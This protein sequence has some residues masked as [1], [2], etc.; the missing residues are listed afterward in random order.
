M[1]GRFTQAYS[2]H[3]LHELYALVG[4]ASNLKPH[5]NIAPTATI[6]VVV[7]GRD[8]RVLVPMRWGLIPAWWSKSEKEVPA[9]FNARAE[10]VA[11]K[12]MFKAAFER[13]R[14]IVPASGYYDKTT[15]AGRQPYYLSAEDGGILS[16]AGVWDRWRNRAGDVLTSCTIIV[17]AAV[18]VARDVHDRM[19]VLLETHDFDAWLGAT[20]GTDLLHSADGVRLRMWPVSTRVNRATPE[21]D[22]DPALIEAIA[23]DPEKVQT[24]RTRSCA[25]SQT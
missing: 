15:P 1:C 4:A 19:P 5:Y 25:I 11:A 23:H 6:D 3:E 14:C 20:A 10:T 17:T 13:N 2:W 16:F 21:N 24:S 9:T 12:P 18:A 8:G 7:P 22:E